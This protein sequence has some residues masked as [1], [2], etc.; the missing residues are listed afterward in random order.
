MKWVKASE[1]FPVEGDPSSLDRVIM[2][3]IYER[4]SNVI[5]DVVYYGELYV[6]ISTH[7]LMVE[8]VIYYDNIEWLDETV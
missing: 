2:R 7:P 1:R 8:E 5:V 4:L 6:E 3:K